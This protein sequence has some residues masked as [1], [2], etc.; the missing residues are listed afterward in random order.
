MSLTPGSRLGPYE[1]LSALGAG[2]MGEVYRA[3]HQARSRRRA[4]DH[5][6]THS[7]SIPIASHGSSAR[8]R[9]WRRSIIRTLP[10]STA[11]RTAVTR[12]RSCW[13]SWK[14][15][16][17]PIGSRAAPIPL[18]EAL[19]IARQI[20]EALE[21]AH[22]Q[23]IIHRDLKPANIKVTPGRRRQGAR[24][25]PRE[26][27]G[28]SRQWAVGSGQCPSVA[29][30]D[31]HVAR[32]DDRRRDAARHRRVHESRTGQGQPADKRSD[33]WAFGAKRDDAHGTRAPRERGCVGHSRIERK[34][35]PDWTALPADVPARRL[36]I[37]S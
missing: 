18:D 21:A 24:L 7:R 33:V 29:V 31:D 8:R 12:T 11:S 15:R 4:E 25:R 27:G 5:L 23:G 17:W 35:D 34:S 28:V 10:P 16:R 37:S 3:R 14:A 26:A 13:S 32:D 22:E 2:G 36:V 19:P 20:A 30:A 1:I 9:C 6:R